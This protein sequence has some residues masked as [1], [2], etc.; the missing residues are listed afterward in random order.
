[1]DASSPRG[2]VRPEEREEKPRVHGVVVIAVPDEKGWRLA[3]F[4]EEGNAAVTAAAAAFGRSRD[5]ESGVGDEDEEMEEVRW[6]ERRVASL[7]SVAGALLVL[8]ALA[9]AGQYCLYYPA[10]EMLREER[11]SSSFLLPL[12]QKASGGGGAARESAA[13]VKADGAAAA[14]GGEARENSSAVLPIRGSVFPD[15]QYYTSMY[16]GNPPRPYFLDVDT[17]SDLTWIQCDAPCTSCAKGPHPLYKPAKQNVVPPRDSYCQELQGNQNYCDTCK[18]CDYEITYADRSSSMGVLARDNMQLTTADGERE[19]LDFVFGCGYDQQGNLLLSPAN[20]DGIL[21]LSNAAISLPTQ[22][23]SQG[24]ISNV[25]GHCIA[26][27][28]SNGGYMFLGDDYVPR[29]GMTW[30]PIRNGPENL[31]STE[32]QKV[33]YGDQQLNVRGKAGKLTQV[34]FDSGSSYTYLPHEEYTNLIASLRSLSP[35]L[36]QDDSDRTLP[37]CMKPNFPVRSV[38]DVKH[39]LKPLSLVFKNR[40]FVLPRTFNI[41][42]EDYLIISDKNNICLGVLDGTEI[43]HDSEIV[44][45]DVSLRGKLVVYNNDEKQIGWVQSDC[46]KPQKQSGFPFLLKRVLQN[47]LL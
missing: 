8:T 14:W 26:A 5:G 27:D 28:P 3:A 12:Y 21:G 37:F 47:Q 7:W 46:T 17:G 41:P 16:I 22:L 30:V 38:Y 39:L 20:T 42:P 44:I 15:G 10:A 32:V 29:W 24:I 34:I 23:A 36:L 13:G 9:V 2:S 45:G 33:N 43:G 4:G 11:R 18:Q 6:R 19:N 25:F 35:S 40:W 31:Y 1:M